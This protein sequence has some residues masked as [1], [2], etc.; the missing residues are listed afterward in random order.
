MNNCL[1]KIA[2]AYPHVKFLRARSDRIGL[3]KYPE[4]GL[5]TLIVFKNGNQMRNLIALHELV[6]M[7]FTAP[8]V[9]AFLVKLRIF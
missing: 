1:A 5:P 7:P 9:E 3:D 6:G 2:I 8:K 4:I